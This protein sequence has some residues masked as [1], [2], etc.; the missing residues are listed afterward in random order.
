[1]K[2]FLIDNFATKNR[3]HRIWWEQSVLSHVYSCWHNEWCNS[4]VMALMK[5]TTVSPQRSL[6]SKFLESLTFSLGFS[7]WLF[8]GLNSTPKGQQTAENTAYYSRCFPYILRNKHADSLEAER[9]TQR[10]LL[11]QLFLLVRIF[12]AFFL[13]STPFKG[14]WSTWLN[15]PET[16]NMEVMKLVKWNLEYIPN[17]S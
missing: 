12:K 11:I 17:G 2:K 10:K 9:N 7:L 1:M 8:S 4:C 15:N 13:W 3:R 16:N 14:L 6:S 5:N